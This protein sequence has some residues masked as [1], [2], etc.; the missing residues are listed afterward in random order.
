MFADLCRAACCPGG[1]KGKC[2]T[3]EFCDARLS[4]PTVLAILRL[5]RAPSEEGIVCRA[6]LDVLIAEGE[7][8]G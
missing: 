4:A 7:R 8:D 5:L 3:P 6:M 2:P 1:R